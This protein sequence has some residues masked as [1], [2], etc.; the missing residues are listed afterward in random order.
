MR[1]GREMYKEYVVTF[2]NLDSNKVDCDC[3]MAKTESEARGDF[4]ECYRNSN[5]KIL[6]TVETGR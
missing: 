3:F 1:G 2:L 4:F 6:S 5:Y